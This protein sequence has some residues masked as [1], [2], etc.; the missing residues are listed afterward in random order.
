[1]RQGVQDRWPKMINVANMANRTLKHQPLP[2][3]PN[4]SLPTPTPAAWTSIQAIVEQVAEIDAFVD[5]CEPEALNPYSQDPAHIHFLD[6]RIEL[7]QLS[8]NLLAGH[9]PNL[10][11]DVSKLMRS[12]SLIPTLKARIMN[13]SLLQLVDD[14]S[15]C[16]FVCFRYT[17]AAIAANHV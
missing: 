7:W 14:L 10:D 2:S 11:L 3:D 13:C 12:A 17:N 15:D 6:L 9:L 8:Y 1:M 16:L 4:S 5:S